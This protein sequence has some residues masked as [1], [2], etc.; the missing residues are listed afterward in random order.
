MADGGTVQLR[1]GVAEDAS[2]RVRAGSRRGLVRL[3]LFLLLPLALI[4]GAYF[5]VTGGRYMSTDNAYIDADKVAVTTD[6][7]GI[8]KSIAVRDNQRVAIGDVLFQLDPEPFRLALER[9]NAQLGTVR[10]EINAMKASYREMQEQIKQ[11]KVDIDFYE[12]EFRRQ[13]D[14]V[15]RQVTS[16]SNF[17]QAR[18]NLDS[19]RQK[20]ASLTQQLSAIVANLSGNPDIA[21]EDH[22]RYRNAVAQ[23]DE[24]ARQL[25]HATVRASI[26]G[27]VTNVPSL[28]PGQ[29]LPASTAAFSIVAT[30]HVWVTANPKETQL[31]HVRPGQKATVTVDTYPGLV[32][33]GVVDSVSPASGATFSLLPAQNTSGNWVK[34]V[35]R[36]PLRV[37]IETPPDR[38][39]LRAGM[40]VEVDVDTGHARGLPR[41]LTALFGGGSAS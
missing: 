35:Q 4:V 26:A 33:E 29:Y 38:P 30:D 6:V 40:S 7:S 41:F 12:R 13:Q 8:V 16:Q 24:A 19:A 34:V 27:V 28:Q 21:P 10:D 31:T 22:P 17:D 2:P 20:L 3:G 9:A 25:A 36:I 18:H 1:A 39:P 23:R 14:L 32:W 11:A 37:R 5:Y 15:S